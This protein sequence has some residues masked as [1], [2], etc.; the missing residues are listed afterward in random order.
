MDCNYSKD[1]TLRAVTDSRLAAY[2]T[3][4]TLKTF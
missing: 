4:F 1:K 2:G 3:K